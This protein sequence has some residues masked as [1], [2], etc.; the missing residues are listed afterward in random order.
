MKMKFG[1]FGILGVSAVA[2]LALAAGPTAAYADAIPYGSIGTPITTNDSLI[3][4]GSSVLFYFGASAADIDAVDIFDVTKDMQTGYIFFNNASSAGQMATLGTSSGDVLVVE[5]INTTEVGNYY[6]VVAGTPLYTTFFGQTYTTGSGVG[7]APATPA[8]DTAP[9]INHV[10][11]TAFSGGTLGATV[12]GPG[13][14]LGAEDRSTPPFSV[15]SDYDYNDDQFVLTGVT[16]STVPEPG[17]IALLGTGI[18]GVAG[19]IRRRLV[20]A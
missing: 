4:T 20:A 11:E 1:K 19:L 12:V 18:L 7:G 16:T 10:Y 6:S 2:A 13:V 9:T 17:S 14:F 3:A 8:P 5:I 15:A